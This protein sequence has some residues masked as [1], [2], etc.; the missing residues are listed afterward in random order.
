[1]V[2]FFKNRKTWL[3]KYIKKYFFLPKYYNDEIIMNSK[4]HV[5]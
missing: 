2:A 4:T 5:Y 3:K 1:M